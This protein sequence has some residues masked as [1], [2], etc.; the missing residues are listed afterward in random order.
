M[1]SLRRRLQLALSSGLLVLL[2]LLWW[3]GSIAVTVMTERFVVSRLQHDAETLLAAL[4]LDDSHRPPVRQGRLSD[5]YQ[6]PL[7][8]HYYQI[9]FADG[10]QLVSR[11]L[12]D[13][14]L[15]IPQFA[16]GSE[17]HW[18]LPG[19]S[20]QELLVR[21][22]GYSKQGTALT[23]A[24]AEDMT[25][26]NRALALFQW[27]FAGLALAAAAL[28]LLLQQLV[29]R[30]GFRRLE[31]LRE[32]VRR[33]ERGEI[34]ALTED[35]PLEVL[36]IVREFNRLLA[37]LQQRI[38]H[39]RNSLGNLA[40]ALKGPLSLLL[41]QIEG[42][43]LDTHPQVRASMA[44]QAARIRQ[45]MERELRRAR[46]AGKGLHLGQ[47]DGAEEM[48]SVVGMLKQLYPEKALEIDYH[49]PAVSR[50]PVDREDMLEL[51][52]NLL[53]NACKWAGSRVVCRLDLDG[54]VGV[55]VEDDGPGVS[56]ELLE[57]LTG[58]GVRVDEST[59]GHGL[60]LSITKDMVLLYG[61]DIHFDRSPELG[62]LR[63]R[64]RLPFTAAG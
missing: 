52:G 10:R 46:L 54:G 14:F 55:C 12:W 42:E 8:G 48:P 61:G 64:V 28:I 38:E 34:S 19:P 25:P 41:R 58:R 31:P 16:P 9:V 53:D 43:A 22:A 63:V 29:L 57:Q 21:V 18:R 20:G 40:H 6:Q 13:Q 27:V 32:D 36:P 50:L 62:G 33:L 30:A 59:D 26:M 60:G 24:V 3:G 37:L 49:L 47:F 39:S 2:A 23:L 45:L 44:E 11:S 35:V 51:L 1:T 4:R 15:D 56:D 5:I 17:G 7:S